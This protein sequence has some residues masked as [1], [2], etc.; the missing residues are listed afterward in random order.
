MATYSFCKVN[1]RTT[2]TS[3]TTKAN[4]NDF[5]FRRAMLNL[6]FGS[7]SKTSEFYSYPFIVTRKLIYG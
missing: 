6:T 3:S 7:I 2:F 1:K 5:I 4:L